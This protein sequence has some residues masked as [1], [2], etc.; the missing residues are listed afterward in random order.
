MWGSDYKIA[1]VCRRYTIMVAQIHH[2]KPHHKTPPQ[3][4]TTKPHH[5]TPPQIPTTNPHQKSLSTT[6]PLSRT[7]GTLLCVGVFVTPHSRYLRHRL[8][9]ANHNRVSPTRCS[10]HS[11]P[12]RP[13]ARHP[14]NSRPTPHTPLDPRLSYLVPLNSSPLPLTPY[15]LPHRTQKKGRHPVAPPHILTSIANLRYFTITFAAVPAVRTM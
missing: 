2:L 5:K 12:H 15:L 1:I 7:S 3:N 4:P 11:P 14:T 9:G 13:T 8:C 10:F 6:L